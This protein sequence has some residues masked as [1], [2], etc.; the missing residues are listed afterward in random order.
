MK[1][2]LLKEFS[3]MTAKEIKDTLEGMC[4]KGEEMQITRQLLPAEKVQLQ[5]ELAD[6][7]INK[8]LLDNQFEKVKQQH[9]TDTAPLKL[10]I[11]E[12]VDQLTTNSFQL[13]GMVYSVADQE[14]AEMLSFDETGS[15]LQSRPLLPE[16]RQRSIITDA[17]VLTD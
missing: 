3:S 4:E 2:E 8:G 7:C 15:Y 14:S 13:E 12:V 5:Q 16:E 6:K 11:S 1:K 10:R 17:K 9:K